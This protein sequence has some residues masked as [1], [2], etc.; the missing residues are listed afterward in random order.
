MSR[1]LILTAGYGEGHNSAARALRT[2]F[3]EQPGVEAE[4]VDLF[5]RKAPRLNDVTR[6]A[7]L[8]LINRAPWIWSGV[9]GW[10]DRSR[11]APLM[12]SALPGHVHLLQRIIAER[13]PVALVS[14]YPVYSWLLRRMKST[15]AL[16]RHFTVVTDAI[17]I[18]SLWYRAPSAGWFV[19]DADSAAILTQ[20]GVTA[21]QVHISGFPVAAAFADRPESLQPPELSSGELPRV[22]YMINSGRDRALETARALIA[23]GEWQ[24]TIT[25]GR[26]VALQE[27]LR[28]LAQSA[29]GPIEILGWTER[30][31]ELLMTHHGVISK[32]GGATTQESIN[33]LCPMIVNQIVPGQEEGNYELLRR[34]GAGTLAQTPGAIVSALRAAFASD[35]ATWRN[36]R[37]NLRKLARPQAARMIARTVLDEVAKP[38]ETA[39]M[40]R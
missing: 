24:L 40:T 1:I 3:D 5:A 17:T 23:A 2:A 6:R 22:L 34:H 38:R 14:T 26:D 15:G 4:L 25:A 9:Y 12:F 39:E 31:P 32:A 7:Y 18:N 33:A 36:W 20:G 19:A 28:K 16:P 8:G 11:A 30:I 35:A 37:A 27:E 29:R 21:D 13:K 10:L